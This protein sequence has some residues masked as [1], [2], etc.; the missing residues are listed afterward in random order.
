MTSPTTKAR[1]TE[2]NFK[3]DLTKSVSESMSEQ[4]VQDAQLFK[5]VNQDI[6]MEGLPETR[7][8]KSKVDSDKDVSCG[9]KEKEKNKDDKPPEPKPTP[10]FLSTEIYLPPMILSSIVAVF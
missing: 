10:H 5:K 6:F 1:V 7:M 4:E 9:D 3:L 2:S 8:S